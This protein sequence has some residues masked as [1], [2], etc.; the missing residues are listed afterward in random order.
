MKRANKGKPANDNR[1]EL[2]GRNRIEDALEKANSLEKDYDNAIN[3]KPDADNTK[4]YEYLNEAIR[5]LT[6]A[7]T[8]M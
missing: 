7:S 4:A 6:G 2:G 8:D 1:A 5:V 3:D